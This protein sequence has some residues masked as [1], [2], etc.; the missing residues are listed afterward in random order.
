VALAVK[1]WAKLDTGGFR[2]RMWRIA[3]QVN[4]A[5]AHEVKI[6][7]ERDLD[8]VEL[9]NAQ[10]FH[11]MRAPDPEADAAAEAL[12]APLIGAVTLAELAARI[13]L[14]PRGLRAL[15][16][17][18]AQHRLRPLRHGRITPQTLVQPKETR[19]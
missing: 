16:R 8:P 13:G 15:V 18:V 2:D 5:F 12:V 6:V 17:R 1:P 11:A 4:D 3:A 14:G 7:T 19:P 9:H 10:L